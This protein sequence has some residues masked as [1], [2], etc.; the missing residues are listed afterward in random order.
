MANVSA[1]LAASRVLDVDG[2]ASNFVTIT[3]LADAPVLPFE[4][5]VAHAFSSDAKTLPLLPILKGPIR[6]S[7]MHAENKV[8]EDSCR[9]LTD[10]AA[11]I[12]FYTQETPFYKALNALLRSRDREKVLVLWMVHYMAYYTCVRACARSCDAK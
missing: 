6:S 4:Q 12:H 8:M 1:V 9:L 11:S 3:G 7:K 10:E 2:D 5:A